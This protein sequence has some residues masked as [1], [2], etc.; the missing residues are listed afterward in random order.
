MNKST[1]YGIIRSI[2]WNPDET[3]IEINL[4]VEEI[5]KNAKGEKV[6]DYID[7]LL[8]AWDSAAT[9]LL[10]YSDIGSHLLVKD[11]SFREMKFENGSYSKSYF[12][13]NDFKIIKNKE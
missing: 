4:S 11:A 6:V 1:F 7:I 13:I 2:H 3:K 10:N 12:R 8:A 9:T 5:R